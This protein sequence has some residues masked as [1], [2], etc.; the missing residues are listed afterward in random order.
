MRSYF[1]LLFAALSPASGAHGQSTEQFGSVRAAMHRFVDSIGAPSVSVAM[2][3]VVLAN[4]STRPAAVEQEFAIAR[5]IAA[6]VLPGDAR[7][8][9]RAPTAQPPSGPPAFI[10]G[11]ELIGDWSGTLRTWQRTVPMRLL[12]AVE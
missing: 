4:T 12:I 11:P 1:A 3:L 5:E 8:A 6:A 9:V 10:P 2:A 7:A